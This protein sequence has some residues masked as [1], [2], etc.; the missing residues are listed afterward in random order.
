MAGDSDSQFNKADRKRLGSEKEEAS[1]KRVKKDE[2]IANNPYLAHMKE[3]NTMEN[4]SRY[5]SRLPAGS[6]FAEFERRATTAKQAAE[7]EQGDNNPF[8][9]EPHSPQYFNILKSRRDLPV[10]KQR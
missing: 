2:D 3:E 10:H 7:A 9:G 4:G 6:P 5:S 8:T 1:A